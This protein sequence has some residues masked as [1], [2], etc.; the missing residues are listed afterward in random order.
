MSV[1]CFQEHYTPEEEGDAPEEGEVV[2]DTERKDICP[3]QYLCRYCKQ[4]PD[5]GMDYGEHITSHCEGI[6]LLEK[7]AKERGGSS[8]FPVDPSAVDSAIRKQLSLPADQTGTL[9][10]T[11]GH[12]RMSIAEKRARQQ[13]IKQAKDRRHSKK[14]KKFHDAMSSSQFRK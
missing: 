13:A 5:Q 11:I 14:Q 4:M 7:Q 8:L 9:L 6:K 10:S 12:K 1:L 3:L 2:P